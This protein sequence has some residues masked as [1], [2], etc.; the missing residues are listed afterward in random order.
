MR[1]AYI[2]CLVAAVLVASANCGIA[3]AEPQRVLRNTDIE[4]MSAAGLGEDVILVT[5]Q[6]SACEFDVSPPALILLKQHHVSDN[7]LKAML[8]RASA[9]AGPAASATGN[10]QRG[11]PGFPRSFFAVRETSGGN[12]TDGTRAS[13]YVGSGRLRLEEGG[14]VTLVDP[15]TLTGYVTEKNQPTRKVEG[16]QGVKGAVVQIGL[17]RY[18]LPIDPGN[19]CSEWISVSCERV[20]SERLDGRQ[21]IHWQVGHQLG[22]R[23]WKSDL[24]VDLEL[25]VASKVQYESAVMHLIGISEAPQP[26]ELFEIPAVASPAAAQ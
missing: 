1:R 5:I 21:V 7:V 18:L 23:T 25:H 4:S 6:G 9:P 10:L 2:A 13:V 20:G 19:P 11:S 15:V 3:S 24:W 8:A 17:S 16:F 22:G 26:V 14:R 12:P